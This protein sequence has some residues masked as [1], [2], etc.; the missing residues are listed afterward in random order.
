[1]ERQSEELL[2]IRSV[3]ATV[4]AGF[5]LYMSNFRSILKLTWAPA[6]LCAIVSALYNH[7]VVTNLPNL[8]AAQSMAGKGGLSQGMALWLANSGLSLLNLIVSLLF[9]SYGFSMLSHHRQEGA[10]P[11]PKS[12][13]TRPDG[14]M[15][16]RTVASALVWTVVFGVAGGLTIGLIGWGIIKGSITTIGIGVLLLLVMLALLLPLVYPNMRYVTTRDTLLFSI[17]GS[18]YLQGLRRWGYQFAVL[19]VTLIFTF[20][21]LVITTLPSIVLMTANMK[22]QT[23]TLMGDP[24]GMPGYMTWMSLIVFLLAGF[25]QCYVVLL[26]HFPAYYMAGSIEKQEQE[27]HEKATNT[28]Y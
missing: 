9:I 6:L 5:R 3:R 21:A 2:K 22:A 10:I 4:A 13:L 17:L 15:L 12:W 25:I 14:R 24:L 11:Y 7:T 28:L 26:L 20:L 27:K 19:L 8:I 16:M 23:G 1:M 18:G